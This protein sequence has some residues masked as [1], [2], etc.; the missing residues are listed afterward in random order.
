MIVGRRTWRRNMD[1][2]G[3]IEE[4]VNVTVGRR[5]WSKAWRDK[6]GSIE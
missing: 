2:Y 5:V 4:K 6:Y 1:K 3:S